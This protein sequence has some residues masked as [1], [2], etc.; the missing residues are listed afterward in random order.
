[1][2]TIDEARAARLHSGEAWADFCDTLKAAGNSVIAHSP[3]G[4]DV[5]RSEG[6]RYLTRMLLMSTFRCIERTTPTVKQPINII[7]PPMSGGIG[8]QSPD[9]DHV[10]Q[11]VDGRYRYHITGE[12]GS[13]RYVHMSAWTP[14]VPDDVGAKPI[15]LAGPD[16][17][18]EFNP[19]SAVTPFTAV[20]DEYTDA[21]GNV[22]FVMA[23]DEQPGN[24]MPMAPGTR[25][26]MMRIVYT[27]RST[28]SK[29]RLSIECLDETDGQ[30]PPTPADMSVRLAN[31]AQLILGIEADYALWTAD[32]LAIENRLALTD[33]HYRRIGGSPDDRHFEFG[34]WRVA[35]D[36]A[37]VVEF[38][39][40][41]CRQWNFQLC[42]HWM[43]NLANYATGAGYLSSEAAEVVDGRVRLVVSHQDPG[44]ANWVNS[45]GRDHGVMGLRFVEPESRPTT[46]CELVDLSSL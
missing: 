19:N 36:K 13:V 10:V 9:Q 16:M 3:D 15:G 26:L 7:P 42:N 32:L 29:P 2:S 31:A 25:E 18:E 27:D 17:L 5:D 43:E 14:P 8:V 41:T 35:P 44:V 46:S 20:L 30:E 12:R 4:N 24:W 6:F 38:D 40:P 39:V 23:V 11:P 37:L 22:D 34:Y 1:M 28:E 21:D 45:G 33:D